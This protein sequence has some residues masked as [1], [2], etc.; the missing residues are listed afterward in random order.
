MRVWL[1]DRREPPAG[2]VWVRTPHEAIDLLSSG[3]VEE[4]SLDHDLGLVDDSGRER[5][6]YDVVLWIEEQVATEALIPP[7]LAVHSANPP[8]HE[9]MLRAIEAINRRT[10]G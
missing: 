10:G 3:E 5:T 9:R 4:L 2:W 1:D 7:R 8:A 6:G